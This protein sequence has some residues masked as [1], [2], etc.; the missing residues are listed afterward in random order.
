MS[1]TGMLRPLIL[2][3]TSRYRM[4]LLKRFGL[5][6]EARSPAV[7]EFE[8]PGEN[9]PRRAARLADAKAEAIA[10]QFPEA[11]VIGGDQVASSQGAI[12]HKPGIAENC[13]AQLSF[14]SENIAEFHTAC[15][16]RCVSATLK[17]S[18]VDTTKVHFRVLEAAEIA[19]YVEREQPYDCAG[20]FKAESLG[21]SLFERMESEDPTAIVG[22]PLIWLADA[23]R[24]AGYEVP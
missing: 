19:R 21:I 8:V 20:G 5:P 4:D 18:H 6:F 15:T 13:Q 22:L 10:R 23:L 14:L 2:A 12:L 11:V 7:D 16:V 1:P 24:T 9:P 17:L 3:S